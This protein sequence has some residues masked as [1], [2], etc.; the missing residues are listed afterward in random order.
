MEFG[1]LISGKFCFWREIFAIMSEN[2]SFID[3]YFDIFLPNISGNLFKNSLVDVF[4]IT[5]NGVGTRL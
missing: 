2:V 3:G 4:F 1:N 5:V